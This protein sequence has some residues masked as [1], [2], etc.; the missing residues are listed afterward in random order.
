MAIYRATGA[1]ARQRLLIRRFQP[2]TLSNAISQLV[3]LGLHGAGRVTGRGVVSTY[4]LGP[5]HRCSATHGCVCVGQ[6]LG[7]A[8]VDGMDGAVALERQVK[9]LE[10]LLTYRTYSHTSF[11]IRKI[12]R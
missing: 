9:R 11:Y 6:Q 2:P 3:L 4:E 8:G 10:Y 7:A 1:M 5:V 12:Q